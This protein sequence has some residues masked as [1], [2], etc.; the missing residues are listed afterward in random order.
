MWALVLGS[1]IKL[2]ELGVSPYLVFVLYLSTL[3]M[4]E[5]MRPWGPFD[6]FQE[7]LDF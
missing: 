4:F 6:R 2:R 1:F 7:V 5:L 3:L